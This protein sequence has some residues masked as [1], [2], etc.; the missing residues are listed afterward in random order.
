V[1]TLLLLLAAC[2]SVPVSATVVRDARTKEAIE[3][4]RVLR[5]LEDASDTFTEAVLLGEAT[6][7]GAGR[8]SIRLAKTQDDCHWVF[9]KP[10][11]A[12][13]ETYGILAAPVVELEPGRA[14]R[15]RLLDP[16]GRPCAG[17]D[18]EALLGCGHSPAVRRARTDRDGVFV[19]E[20]LAPTPARLWFVAPGLASHCFD[21]SP[22]DFVADPGVVVEGQVVDRRGRPARG[23][24]VRSVQEFRGPRATCGRDGRFRLVGVAR[25]EDLIACGRDGSVAYLSEADYEPGVAIRIRLGTP[26]DDQDGR[27]DPGAEDLDVRVR[28]ADAQGGGPV[29]GVA[30]AL[31]RTADGRAFRAETAANGD[32]DL[33]APAGEYD[34]RVGDEFASHVA[35]P[36]RVRVRAAGEA[37]RI[38]AHAQ[39]VLE[40]DATRLPAG[41][42]LALVL[43]SAIR[44]LDAE[45]GYRTRLPADA[46]A[47]VRL[48]RDGDDAA[49]AGVVRTL[50]VGPV[51][52]GV[53]RA[54]P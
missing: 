37:L 6:T 28:V 47:A 36:V 23:A 11:Y 54:R 18:V 29:E 15:G 4:A 50:P 32:A 16:W 14:V 24:V 20:D 31:L 13:R 25:G 39:P 48:T 35:P 27:T 34:L 1:R 12:V 45:D 46:P 22:G 5:Y 40:V 9:D 30:V 41:A 38:V 17:I 21:V 2:T 7:D 26:S 8:A 52:G 10:G 44:A 19:L 43:P 51:E 33:R 3:G 42:S 49:S 53:R